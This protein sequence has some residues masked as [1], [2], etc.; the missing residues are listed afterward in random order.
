MNS[1]IRSVAALRALAACIVL[2]AAASCGGDD[3]SPTSPSTDSAPYS[4]TDIRVGTGTEATAGRRATVNYGGWFYSASAAENKGR[5]FDAGAF[6]LTLGAGQ[7]IRGFDQGV[8]GMR[9]GGIRRL[10]IPPD[11]AYGPGGSSD[12]RIPPNATLLFDIELTNVQ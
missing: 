6:A 10:V 8:T 5:Q 2:I 3:S 11:L 4:Q 12:G 9:V 7:V 1:R